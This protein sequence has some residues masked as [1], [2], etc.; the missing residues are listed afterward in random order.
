MHWQ[1]SLRE[2]IDSQVNT[3][4][5]FPFRHNWGSSK[6]SKNKRTSLTSH[7]TGTDKL[8]T[9]INKCLKQCIANIET[10]LT[11]V[12]TIATLLC[13]LAAILDSR[14]YTHTELIEANWLT[15][16][17]LK[18]TRRHFLNPVFKHLNNLENKYVKTGVAQLKKKN[19]S[20]VDKMIW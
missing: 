16:T 7:V 11:L 4:D 1:E 5:K 10:I 8:K 17:E 3:N 19:L 6:L 13:I 9:K 20:A 14:N 18:V 15:P 2:S 12:K